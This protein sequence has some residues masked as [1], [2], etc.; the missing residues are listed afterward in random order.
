VKAKTMLALETLSRADKL[1]LMEALWDDL[2]ANTADLAPPGW[3]GEALDAAR[4]AHADGEAAFI[5]WRKAKR[6]LRGE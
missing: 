4:Q 5:D 6:Q 3:H 2:A 1:K